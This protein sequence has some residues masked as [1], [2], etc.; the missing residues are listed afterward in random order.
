MKASKEMS[1]LKMM[2]RNQPQPQPGAGFG[3]A[4]KRTMM[5]NQLKE[6]LE[7]K[8]GLGMILDSPITLDSPHTLFSEGNFN[9]IGN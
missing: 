1:L 2:D 4:L 7:M 9:A 5:E 3:N 6:S 8:D